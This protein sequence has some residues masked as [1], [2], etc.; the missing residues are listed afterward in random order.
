VN[1][2]SAT[3][4]TPSGPRTFKAGLTTDIEPFTGNAQAQYTDH[5]DLWG[6]CEFDGTAVVGPSTISLSL[7]D[8]HG[9][10]ITITGNLAG[11]SNR[12]TLLLGLGC[13][14]FNE[15]AFVVWGSGKD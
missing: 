4:C 1:N 9:S 13:G 8:G 5:D 14:V 10:P 2:L 15:R 3:F 6:G 11:V 7:K 12:S